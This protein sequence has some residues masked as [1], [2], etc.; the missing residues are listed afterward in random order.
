MGDKAN[1]PPEP[2][3]SDDDAEDLEAP[4]RDARSKLPAGHPPCKPDR[5]E[6]RGQRASKVFLHTDHAEAPADSFAAVARFARPK[7]SLAE[8]SVH[9]PLFVAQGV[10][11]PWVSGNAVG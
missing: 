8:S 5:L 11:W 9:I 10:S 1:K 6:S 3:P 4:R 2:E 7:R